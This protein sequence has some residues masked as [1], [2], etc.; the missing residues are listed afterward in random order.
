MES[1][2]IFQHDNAAVTK[3][4]GTWVMVITYLTNSHISCIKNHS[5][6]WKKESHKTMME[7][8]QE[9]AVCGTV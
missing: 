4:T 9:W 5:F 2:S 6:N 7:L 1:F 8:G 3:Y